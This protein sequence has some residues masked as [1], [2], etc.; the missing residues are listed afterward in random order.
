MNAR[1]YI[2]NVPSDDIMRGDEIPIQCSEHCLKCNTALKC[3]S[4]SDGYRLTSNALRSI[5]RSRRL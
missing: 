3:T 2:N 1:V 4:Y 5:S